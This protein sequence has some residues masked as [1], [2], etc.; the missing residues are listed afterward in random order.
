MG[1]PVWINEGLA[2][3]FKD[4]IF[5]GQIMKLGIANGTTSNWFAGPLPPDKSFS[6]LNWSI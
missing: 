4:G 6:L 1:L 2:Q 5:I 3:Y